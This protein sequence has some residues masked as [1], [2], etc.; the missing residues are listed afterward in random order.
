MRRV[1]NLQC[2][3]VD[4]NKAEVL[5]LKVQMKIAGSTFRRDEHSRVSRAL[6][7]KFYLHISD[8]GES[9]NDGD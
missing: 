4:N 1:L 2:Y 6:S 3:I 9:H 8:A 7:S 5:L